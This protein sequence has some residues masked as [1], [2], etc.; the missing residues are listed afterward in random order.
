MSKREDLTGQR[1]GKLV[2]LRP[3]EPKVYGKQSRS[4]WVCQCDCGNIKTIATANLKNGSSTSCGCSKKGSRRIDM[5]GKI[6]NGFQVLPET[7]Y[8]NDDSSQHLIWHCECLNCHRKWWIYGS[9]LRKGQTPDCGCLDVINIKFSHLT[10]YKYHGSS[11]RGNLWDC[12]C[13]CG[14]ERICNTTDLRSGKA[15]FCD[16][17]FHQDEIQRNDGKD[18]IGQRFGLLTVLRKAEKK[19]ISTS[20]PGIFWVCKCECGNLKVCA[21]ADLN[22]GKTK[23]CGCLKSFGEAQIKRILQQLSIS[24]EQEY[25]FQDLVSKKNNPLRFDFAIFKENVLALLIEYDGKQHYEQPNES[26]MS[27]EDFKTL[28]HHDS[29]KND[30]CE[31]H[32]IPLIR[33]K[34]G[35]NQDLDSYIK[36][37][38]KKYEIIS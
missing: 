34:D 18:L 28:Q 17:R 7:K 22:S 12:R 24:F 9:D 38:L 1:F 15:K 5:S 32:Q 23:S 21:A 30:Y 13:D 4:T 16:Q 33:I 26:W 35:E 27:K 36:E 8:E 29:L 11:P 2:C 37:I 10:P 19:E 20:R 31:K 3:G 25:S 14:R 6:I